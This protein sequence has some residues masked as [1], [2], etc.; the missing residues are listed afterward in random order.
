MNADLN[1]NEL[2]TSRRP[3]PK[4]DRKATDFQ[5]CPYCEGSFAALQH[6]VAYKCNRK[7]IAKNESMKCQRIIT[8][9]SIAVE[10]RV[11]EK[12]SQNLKALFTSFRQNEIVYL[13]RFEWLIVLYGNKICQK[14]TK[15]FQ[16]GMKRYRIKMAGRILHA[17]KSIDV[18]D[19]A[20]IYKP[21]HY[22][23]MVEAI[24]IVSRFDA[25]SN[26]F[27]APACTSTAVTLMRKLGSF[28][29]G[30]YIKMSDRDNLQTTRDFI[31]L[32]NTEIVTDISYA[33]TETQ[34]ENQR[35]RI[36]IHQ[37]MT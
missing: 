32:I 1:K 15:S 13:S 24:R 27:G 25:K 17:L 14:N 28:L 9:L 29:V 4:F 3:N 33:V 7:P 34:K 26:K 10:G 5:P 12:A 31:E 22:D 18:T 19:F 21:K 30:A 8:A 16:K 35:D 6:H 23:S 36:V 20:S 11:H 37:Q 2:M